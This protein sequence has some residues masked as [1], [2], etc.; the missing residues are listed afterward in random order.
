[1]QFSLLMRVMDT[2]TVSEEPILHEFG[3]Q[4]LLSSQLK[5]PVG[6][7]ETIGLWCLMDRLDQILHQHR[8]VSSSC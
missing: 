2:T 8:K 6:Y 5:I 4:S 3:I 1:M 7:F